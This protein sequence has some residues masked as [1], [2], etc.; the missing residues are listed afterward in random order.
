MIA[1]CPNPFRDIGL[2]VTRKTISILTDAGYDTA[3]CP[4]FSENNQEVLPGDL[5]YRL[6]DDVAASCTLIIVIGG[7]GTILHVARTADANNVP[8]LGVNL[9]TKGFMSVLETGDLPLILKAAKN[10]V[11][12]SRRMKLDAALIRDGKTIYTD[13]ALN[14]A[15]VH[16]YGDCV[17]LT[18]W[19]NEERIKKF[20]GDGVIIASPTGSTGYSL[21]A[22]GPIVEPNAENIIVSPICAHAMGSRC[23]VL[24]PERTIKV[25]TEKLHGRRA[26]L[27]IDG[28]SV[29]DLE[30]EDILIVK[31][32]AQCTQMVDFGLKSFYDT[33][34]EKLI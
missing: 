11:T 24:S 7:D 28:S 6:L 1:V 27:S 14:D 5:E 17:K 16:G 22:G 29:F 31:R 8:L 4:V 12:I 23:F 19:C 25:K 9:G 32:S 15:V 18:V 20:S 33:T 34:Y 10:E 2:D 30:N 21:S 13:C 26:Y 3:V